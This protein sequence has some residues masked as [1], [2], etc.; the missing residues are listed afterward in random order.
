M[1]YTE[2]PPPPQDDEVEAARGGRD[3]A[4]STET[5]EPPVDVTDVRDTDEATETIV[6]GGC[7]E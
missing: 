2:T 3:V 5:L 1:G 6:P 7:W 4:G